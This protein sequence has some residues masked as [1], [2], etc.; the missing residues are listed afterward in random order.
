MSLGIMNNLLH[1]YSRNEDLSPSPKNDIFLGCC[2]L[3][4]MV[5][6]GKIN[7]PI[8]LTIKQ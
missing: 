1:E 4:N 8:S 2:P 6:L 7:L 5:F 3:E